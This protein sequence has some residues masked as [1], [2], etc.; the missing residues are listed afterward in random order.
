MSARRDYGKTAT[1]AAAYRARAHQANELAAKIRDPE[2]RRIYKDIARQWR[3]LAE[4]IER[5]C[6]R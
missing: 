4:E 3:E 1:R 5:Y 6:Q 2:A